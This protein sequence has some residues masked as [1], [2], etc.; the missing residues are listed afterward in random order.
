MNNTEAKFTTSSPGQIAYLLW[1]DVYPDKLTF[2][3]NTACL[4]Y[5]LDNEIDNLIGK[6]WCGYTLPVCEITECYVVASKILKEQRINLRWYK[7]MKEAIRE[8]RDDYI[9]PVMI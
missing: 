6:Y 7:E 3:P 4:Y 8:V 5:D 9:Q 1:C 2:N